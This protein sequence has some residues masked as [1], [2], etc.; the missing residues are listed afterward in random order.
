MDW[1]QSLLKVDIRDWG[2]EVAIGP[3]LIGLVFAA[4]V[5]RHL[6]G[7]SH[8]SRWKVTEVKFNFGGLADY[9]LLP[10]DDVA[11]I[12]HEAWTELAT[13]KAGIRV[14]ENDVIVEVYDSWYVLFA[15]LRQLAREVPVRVLHNSA[16]GQ[17]LL[18]TL[19]DA[20][21]LGLRP[22]LTTY[23]ATFRD[24]WAKALE[25]PALMELTPTERQREYSGYNEII[26]EMRVVNDGLID[27]AESLRRLAHE[28]EVAPA[29]IRLVRWVRPSFKTKGKEIG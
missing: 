2:I 23:Q 5:L 25:D 9:S 26:R 16:D 6:G 29:W 3:V 10:D 1:W 19:V 21:N 15:S 17:K 13:R 18:N 8:R 24:W 4:F 12:A 14:D 7:Q 22:H 27:M 11:R 20:M 28:R